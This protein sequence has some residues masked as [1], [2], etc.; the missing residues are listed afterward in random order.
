[1]ICCMLKINPKDKVD[2]KHFK[3]TYCSLYG[4]EWVNKMAG[5]PSSM[6]PFRDPD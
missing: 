6:W 5:W 4:S 1:M 3:F 2:E